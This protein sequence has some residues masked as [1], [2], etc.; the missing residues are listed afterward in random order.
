[1]AYITYEFHFRM[2]KRVYKIS[3]LYKGRSLRTDWE[4][5]MILKALIPVS[6]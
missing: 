2:A 5:L 3:F 1:M 4:G 6:F